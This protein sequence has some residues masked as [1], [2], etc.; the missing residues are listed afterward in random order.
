VREETERQ[1]QRGR[2]GGR[3]LNEGSWVGGSVG[4]SVNEK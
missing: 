1:R 4:R 2:E 3:A